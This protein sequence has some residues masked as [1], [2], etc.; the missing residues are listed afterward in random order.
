MSPKVATWGRCGWVLFHSV[1]FAYSQR[2]TLMERRNML[3]FLWSLGA[4]LPCRRCRKHYLEYLEIHLRGG[5][6]AA[7]LRDRDT[8]SRFTVALHNDVNRR[9][10][11]PIVTYDT[12]RHRYEVDD[13][14][15]SGPW[16]WGI[17]ALL[18]LIVAFLV[19]Y[20][21]RRQHGGGGGGKGSGSGGGSGSSRR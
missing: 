17:G 16:G 18:V 13:D 4:V 11:K 19:V 5:V 8:L 7:A 10:G 15:E 9:L 12:V 2:P 21:W 1:A 6:N 3:D 14:E 20:V